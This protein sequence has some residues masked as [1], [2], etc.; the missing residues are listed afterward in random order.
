MQDDPSP[1]LDRGLNL[2]HATS[3]NM[4]NMWGAGLFI[5]I[6]LL[7]AAWAGRKR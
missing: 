7:L 1:K 2:V 3:L 5:T 4:A 6:P